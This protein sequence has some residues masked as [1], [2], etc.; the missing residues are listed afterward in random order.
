MVSP[1]QLYATWVE[2]HILMQS[3]DLETGSD[4]FVNFLTFVYNR[5]FILVVFYVV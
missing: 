5:E 2:C 4:D 1:S 3:L